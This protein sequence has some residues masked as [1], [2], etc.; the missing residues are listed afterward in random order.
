MEN[1]PI[2]GI[3]LAAFLLC[4]VPVFFGLWETGERAPWK[5]W[6]TACP[7]SGDSCEQKVAML[8]M[9]IA[10]LG[11][12]TRES[13]F[14]APPEQSVCLYN[15]RVCFGGPTGLKTSTWSLAV[16]SCVPKGV[17]LY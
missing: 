5:R 13:S 2:H 9:Q 17:V 11:H 10:L 6:K 14:E 16:S 7:C 4:L 12:P 3:P 15:K 8:L 1:R